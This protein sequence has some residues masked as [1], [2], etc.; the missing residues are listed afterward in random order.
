MSTLTLMSLADQVA[1]GGISANP[2]GITELAETAQRLGVR[3]ILV[4]ILLDEAEPEV[5]RIR[6]FTRVTCAVSRARWSAAA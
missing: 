6:A 1:Q 4:D 2:R 5:A 3:P